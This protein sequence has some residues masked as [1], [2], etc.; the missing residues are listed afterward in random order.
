V[1]F[2][3]VGSTLA[4]GA[5]NVLYGSAARLTGT[6]SQLFHQD[7]AGVASVADPEDGFG[8]A[9]TV[10]DFNGDTFGDLAVGVPFE[11]VGGRLGAGAVNVLYGTAGKLTGTGSQ[12]FNQNTTGVASIAELSD[13]FGLAITAADFN[14]DM[15]DDLAVGAAGETVND[16]FAAGAVNVLYGSAGKLS[17]AGSQL[18]N[19]NTTGVPDTAEELDTFGRALAASGP[20][21]A[22]AAQ[23]STASSQSAGSAGS[24]SVEQTVPRR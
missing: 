1:P 10:G 11:T 7:I 18:F 3:A 16:Q 6:G 17:G 2:E 15:F 9:L 4:A 8:F 24:A 23:A 14:R 12:L 19:Q 20:H 21:N 22:T 5:A 13:V